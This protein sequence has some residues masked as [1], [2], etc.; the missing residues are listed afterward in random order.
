MEKTK[1]PRKQRKRKEEILAR[2]GINVHLSKELRSKYNV[3]AFGLRKGDEVKVLRGKFK[4][5]VGKVEKVL[6]R[7]AK[8]YVE[9]IQIQKADGTKAK[10]AIHPSNLMI[11]GLDLSDKLRKSKIEMKLKGETK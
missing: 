9:G 3:R 11:T 1:S 8:V 10:V 6:P 5:K 2:K 7:K 4:G